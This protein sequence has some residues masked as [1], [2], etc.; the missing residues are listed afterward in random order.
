[1]G[2]L[3]KTGDKIEDAVHETART[4]RR[5]A[6]RVSQAGDAAGADI[7]ALLKDL[8]GSLKASKDDDV[9]ALRARLE[10]RLA[11]ARATFDDTQSTFRGKI[12]AAVTTT[13]EYV[14]GRPWE[15]IGA[16]AGIAFLLGIII[17]RG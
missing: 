4:G 6:R 9:A 7:R 11:D 5:F 12:G 16:A 8:E 1:M 14:R 10:S 15:T 3:N 13:D 17:G 2:A